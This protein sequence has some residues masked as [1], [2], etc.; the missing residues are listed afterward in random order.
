[1]LFCIINAVSISKITKLR[2]TKALVWPV[3]SLNVILGPQ[4][5]RMFVSKTKARE[6]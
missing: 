1:M 5:K 3:A 2:L 6:R 4:M